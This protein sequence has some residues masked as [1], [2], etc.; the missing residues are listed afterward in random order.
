MLFIYIV[1][2][3]NNIVIVRTKNNVTSLNEFF[4]SLICIDHTQ[5]SFVKTKF[6]QVTFTLATEFNSF[7]CSFLSCV[8]SFP[9]DMLL[10]V[11]SFILWLFASCC[12][13]MSLILVSPSFSLSHDCALSSLTA[14]YVSSPTVLLLV[15]WLILWFCFICLVP[16]SCRA[17]VQ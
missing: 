4:S 14:V 8:L 9:C 17:V 1:T 12:F 15:V 11:W 6:K 13:A 3:S 2:I 5:P 7:C 16:F 10:Y